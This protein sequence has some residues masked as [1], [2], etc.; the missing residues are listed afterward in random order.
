M[1]N[2]AY[3]HAI[4]KG[5]APGKEGCQDYA[6]CEVAEFSDGGRLAI[7]VVSD[8]AG[9]AR[10]AAEG[11]E[12][13]CKAF[14]REARRVVGK[15]RSLKGMGQSH[16]AKIVEHV[17]RILNLHAETMGSR[18]ADYS[19]TLVA[20]LVAE[21]EALFFQIG[22]GAI[23]Y[24]RGEDFEVAIWP[25]HGEYVN[26]TVFVTDPKCGDRIQVC[27]INEP[28]ESVVLFSD[29]LQFL[30]LDYKQM[31]PHAPFFNSVTKALSKQEPGRSEVVSKWLD[32]AVLASPSV[33]TKTDDDLSLVVAVRTGDD[34]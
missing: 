7:G 25:D 28:I 20:A 1:A 17:R 30:V 16:A 8:G 23:V 29:G 4:R 6:I 12:L 13:A 26:E 24:R 21:G 11:A 27:K 34:A 14:L 3:A 32:E 31:Q 9:S 18:V 10:E 33:T 15:R 19:C 22:D 2:W 5:V